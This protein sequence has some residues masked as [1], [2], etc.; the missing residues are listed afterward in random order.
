MENIKKD[1][2]LELAPDF[3][4]KPSAFKAELS[5]N[6]ETKFDIYYDVCKVEEEGEFLYF[7]MI[8]NTAEAPFYYNVSY[9]IEQ[10]HEIHSIF[11]SVNLQELKG[12]LKILFENKRINLSF[13]QNE[14]IIKMELNV[15]LFLPCYKIYFELYREMIP[16]QEKDKKLLDLYSLQKEKLKLLKKFFSFK[17]NN[18]EMEIIKKLKQDFKDLVIPGLEI[19]KEV[20]VLK[21]EF[22]GLEDSDIL[23]GKN[24]QRRKTLLKKHKLCTNLMEKYNLKKNKTKIDLNLRNNYNFVWPFG[25][26]LLVCDE[27]NSNIKPKEIQSPEYEIG[28]KEDGD[29]SVI[30]DEK[31]LNP[32][33][34][35]C[36]LRLSIEGNIIDD[37]YIELD[38]RVKDGNIK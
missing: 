27:E 14:E 26:T 31:D 29:F 12:Y 19:G 18:E 17:G 1:I 16:A 9:T 32:G 15:Y 8:E 2:D 21:E 10:L 34:Y 11:K 28:K 7:K 20:K 35:K 37:S 24:R 33:K 38:I 30:F 36:N 22:N 23:E 3:E 6:N 5:L 25:K 4:N 13:D